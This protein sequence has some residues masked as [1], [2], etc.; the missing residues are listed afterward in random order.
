MLNEIKRILKQKDKLMI[1]EFHKKKTQM[2]PPVDHRIAEEYVE[3][4]GN[5]RGLKTIN[6]FPLG[7][8]SIA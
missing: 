3:E 5:S 8:I 7:D 4:M 6:K 1:I 2:G